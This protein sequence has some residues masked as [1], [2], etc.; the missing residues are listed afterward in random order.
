MSRQARGEIPTHCDVTHL[1]EFLIVLFRGC[2]SA[3]A[4]VHRWK[5]NADCRN[6]FAFMARTGEISRKKA[7]Q[8]ERMRGQIAEYSLVILVIQ[9][10]LPI[11]I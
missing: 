3:H 1:A 8:P 6:D 2:R 9:N 11:T 5:N 7:P 10:Q 4:K